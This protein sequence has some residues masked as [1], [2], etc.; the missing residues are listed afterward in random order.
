MR[1]PMWRQLPDGSTVLVHSR[2]EADKYPDGISLPNKPIS[3]QSEEVPKTDPPGDS[4]ET[5]PDSE[6][7]EEVP[8]VPAEPEQ[9]KAPKRGPGRPRKAE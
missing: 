6:Q 1:F 2:E 9:A 4:S 8:E 5:P 7:A 3:E